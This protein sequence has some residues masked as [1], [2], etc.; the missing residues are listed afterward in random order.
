M[1][2]GKSNGTGPRHSGS[3]GSAA[4]SAHPNGQVGSLNCAEFF[5]NPYGMYEDESIETAIE[6]S[7]GIMAEAVGEGNREPVILNVYD[8]FW[9]NEYTGNMGLGVYHSGLEVYGREY[10]YGGHPFPFSGIFDIAPRAAGEL[11]E[12]FR[13]KQAI[14]LG[15]TDF[16]ACDVEKILE[17]LGREFRGD[18]YHLMSRNCNHFSGAFS[19]ILCG[20]ETPG[21]V[22]RLAYFSTCVPF[23]QRCL[24]KE[25]L[26][27]HALEQEIETRNQKL[28][29]ENQR[30]ASTAPTTATG[31]TSSSSRQSASNLEGSSTVQRIRNEFAKGLSRKDSTTSSTATETT[32]MG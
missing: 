26:T 30:T 31:E 13:F 22:N 20:R 25:W 3:N 9:T 19:G 8:M 1:S 16:R 17:E 24:P 5:R 2:N 27:P 12:Q 18:R 7:P 32:N 28:Q 29:S 4:G 14:H 23:L 21:W 15:N 6:A 10:A 11:G